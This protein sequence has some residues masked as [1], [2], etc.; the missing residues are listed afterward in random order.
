MFVQTQS[1]NIIEGQITMHWPTIFD[2]V[3]VLC[4]A[5]Y[6]LAQATSSVMIG[7]RLVNTAFMGAFLYEPWPR[8]HS[9]LFLGCYSM[10]QKS[11]A[12]RDEDSGTFQYPKTPPEKNEH[13]LIAQGKEEIP[14]ELCW[15]QCT[16]RTT[17]DRRN[18]VDFAGLSGNKRECRCFN[19]VNYHYNLVTENICDLECDGT[20]NTKQLCRDNTM[21]VYLICYPGFFHPPYCQSQCPHGFCTP[22]NFPKTQFADFH[23]TACRIDGQ[24]FDR[25]IGSDSTLCHK[26]TE[27]CQVVSLDDKGQ[28]NPSEYITEGSYIADKVA[29]NSS[30]NVYVLLDRELT[31]S[32]GEGLTHGMPFITSLLVWHEN[33]GSGSLMTVSKESKTDAEHQDFKVIYA[34]TLHD[35]G[36]P[37]TDYFMFLP[38]MNANE[39]GEKIETWL[40]GSEAAYYGIYVEKISASKQYMAVYFPQ[41]QTDTFSDYATAKIRTDHDLL[42]NTII[43]MQVCSDGSNCQQ[44]KLVQNHIKIAISAFSTEAYECSDLCLQK[45]CTCAGTC[46]YGCRP[47]KMGYR[48]DKDCPLGHFGLHCA[49]PCSPGCKSKS[50]HAITGECLEGCSQEGVTGAYCT[51][52]CPKGYYGQDC[53]TLCSPHC[54]DPADCSGID[55][56]CNGGCETGYQG[57]KCDEQCDEGFFGDNC[58]M[59]CGKCRMDAEI[60]DPVTGECPTGCRDTSVAEPLCLCPAD[61]WNIPDCD[62]DCGKCKEGVCDSITGTCVHNNTKDE[63]IGD[64]AAKNVGESTE[65]PGDKAKS[66]LLACSTHE[67]DKKLCNDDPQINRTTCEKIGCCFDNTTEKQCFAR[68]EEKAANVEDF[69]EQWFKVCGG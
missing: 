40:T 41:S 53:Q 37:K 46:V 35:L 9:H 61:K 19:H 24:C 54:I 22:K 62:K 49:Y 33:E 15:R 7:G 60:C 51:E 29:D 45:R 5:N 32:T 38:D 59:Q 64:E 23:V 30:N 69:G 13:K 17:A 42:V 28:S 50:C 57:D 44:D 12:E 11:Q 26:L 68:D 1:K 25:C 34:A 67:K 52:T 14:Y 56:K 2:S 21:K 16:D 27:R 20:S 58:E 48:C 36:Y 6:A 8:H 65:D 47:G 3:L 10:A 4:V 66:D 63:E 18:S 31:R 55:G 43:N 39:Q